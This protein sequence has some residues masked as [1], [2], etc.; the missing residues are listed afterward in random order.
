MATDSLKSKT[1]KGTVWGALERFSSQGI[2]FIVT[3]IMARILTPDDYGLVG[4]VL[5]FV[6][7]A[8]TLIDSGFSQALIRK[9]DRNETDNST[10]F[11]FNLVIGVVL[12]IVMWFLAPAIASFYNEPRLL[13]I[14]RVICLGILFVCLA[15]V[16]RALFT[17]DIDFKTQAKATLF[18]AV[19]AGIAGIGMAY[20]GLGV[21]SIVFYHIIILGLN[22]LLLW[23][24]SSW[25]PK[26]M[27]SW[28]SFKVLF[29]FGY[30]LALS[31]L[32]HS[33]YTNGF[34][35]VIGKFYK[36][37]DLGY[38]TR[39]Q[40]FV[41]FF[42]GTISGII[43]RVSYPVMC[44]FQDDNKMLGDNFLK[45]IRIS[46]FIVFPCMMGMVG[47]AYPMIG[48]LLGEKWLYAAKLMQILCFGYMWFGV[49]SLNLNILLVKGRSDL[50]LRLEIIKKILFV[51]VLIGAIPL[52]LEAM[53]W[54]VV[55]NSIIEVVVNSFYTGKFIGI[56]IW[57]QLKQLLPSLFYSVSMGFVSWL[58]AFFIHGSY[59]I[60]FIGGVSAGIVYY[61]F[62][63]SITKSS[64]LRYLMTFIKSQKGNK[65][66]S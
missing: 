20:A 23:F 61:I 9:Q 65:S 11:Y 56:S 35:M 36:A 62:I 22:T 2:S 31:G 39:G 14:T 42:S 58:A 8:L 38:Y 49:Y 28:K 50:Y 59:F 40:Q 41:A 63:T 45:M 54:A 52:G 47:V 57:C 25:H 48:F 3:I 26:W 60:Q 43:Q 4:M 30:K 46:S 27:F 21:W 51:G 17:I 5:V 33:I 37:S 18:S 12:Y 44:R 1:F 64:D 15:V 13:W 55:V 10:A 66:Y 24:F 6:H 19:T 7:I 29:G 16:Q 32:M 34:N 53:C